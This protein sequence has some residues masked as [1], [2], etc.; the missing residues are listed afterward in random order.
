M[1][2]T[3]SLVVTLLTSLFL[4]SCNSASVEKKVTRDDIKTESDKLSYSIGM[5]MGRNF[6]NQN[7][8]INPELFAKGMKDFMA[9]EKTLLTEDEVK[10]VFETYRKTLAE[11]QGAKAK[12]AGE[13][14]K[15]EGIAFLAK[16]KTEKDVKSLPSGLLFK[17]IKEGTGK[18][19]K[20]EDKVK[21]HYRGTLLN[22]KEFDSSYKRNEPV[23]FQLKQ[24]IK[25]WQEGLQ[26]MKEGAKYELYIPS[27]LG[28]G[29]SGIGADIGPDSTLIFE[30]ELLK[31]N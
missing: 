11:K 24:V 1:N 7:M 15:K 27:E 20:L 21:V 13:G 9:G 8:E 2:K 22:G 3:K 18:M 23:E 16:K 30:V 26:Q 31:V 17:V 4:I 12:Q 29:S 19:P 5:D 28:Y 10:Q 25:G 6:K 14:N